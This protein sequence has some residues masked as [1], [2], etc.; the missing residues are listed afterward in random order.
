MP[1]NYYTE[2]NKKIRLNALYDIAKDRVTPTSWS[3]V[4]VYNGETQYKVVASFVEPT[5]KVDGGYW[6]DMNPASITFKRLFKYD[7]GVGVEYPNID[8]Y[9]TSN[10]NS[11]GGSSSPTLTPAQ[12]TAYVNTTVANSVTGAVTTAVNN[13]VITNS[14]APLSGTADL[15]SLPSPVDKTLKY[16]ES[17]NSI[18]AYDA[19]STV[20]ADGNNI[21][22]PSSGV[23]RWIKTNNLDLINGGTF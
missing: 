20:A 19:Q 7:G 13:A 8:D 23:G 1:I 15:I 3:F 16:I 18:Y 2:I 5:V 21:I 17:N 22:V 6:F 14:V 9:F 10:T 4:N 11:G 12:I